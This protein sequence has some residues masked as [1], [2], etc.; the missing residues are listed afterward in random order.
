MSIQPTLDLGETHRR[1]GFHEQFD[2][3]I[4]GPPP[5]VLPRLGVEALAD[6][7]RR[8]PRDEFETALRHK[9]LPIVSIPGLTL[10]AA[11]GEAAMAM[12]RAQGRKVVAE[13]DVASF[14]Q[15]VRHTHGP[16][17]LRDATHGFALGHPDK[18]ASRRLTPFQILIILMLAVTVVVAFLLLPGPAVW[19]LASLFGGLFFLAVIALRILCLLPPVRRRKVRVRPLADAELPV[20]SVLVPLFREVS[21][22]GQLLRALMR[23]DYPP[24]KLDIK[25]ILEESDVLMQRAVAGIRL[26]PQFEVIVVP[27]GKPQTKPRALNYGLRFACGEL[28]T[29]FDAEDIPEPGQL[30]LAAETFASQPRDVA[31]LQAELVFYNS[32]ENWLT[33]QFTI[34]YATLFGLLLPALA[35]HRLPL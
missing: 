34:E 23:L 6:A 16:L 2:G 31:C 4:A 33:R 32:N 3:R 7:L 17:L 11:C 27:C 13:A 19:A 12:A 21:V 30:R 35:N 28:L 8:L 15:A 25:I 29:I 22:L 24:E 9:I 1:F 20:Y 5:E 18:S 26:P 14:Q 10:H